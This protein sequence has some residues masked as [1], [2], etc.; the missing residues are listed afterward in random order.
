MSLNQPTGVPVCGICGRPL[1]GGHTDGDHTGAGKRVEYVVVAKRGG[2]A[3]FREAGTDSKIRKT[4][5]STLAFQLGVDELSLPGRRFSCWV[6]PAEYGIIRS[7]FQLI[8][9]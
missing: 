8:D 7:D 6:E 9:S 1:D 4:E 3:E 5:A 2:I